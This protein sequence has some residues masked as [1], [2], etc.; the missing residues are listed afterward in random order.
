M[1]IQRPTPAEQAFE[2]M[3]T[4]RKLLLLRRVFEQL[5]F[6]EDGEPGG[7]WSSDTTQALGDLFNNFGVVFTSPDE[8][9]A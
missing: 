2:A 6:D 9:E 7:E 1:T 3:P 8:V 4:D 5:E